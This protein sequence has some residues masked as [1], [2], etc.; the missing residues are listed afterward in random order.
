MVILDCRDHT[1][2]DAKAREIYNA[3]CDKLGC[4]TAERDRVTKQHY[5]PFAHVDTKAVATV[6]PDTKLL[7]TADAAKVVTVAKADEAKWQPVVSAAEAEPMDDISSEPLEE[8]DVDKMV[9]DT[10]P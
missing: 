2:A 6:V 5:P 8:S 10:R 3:E 4:K 9:E 1:E 7:T